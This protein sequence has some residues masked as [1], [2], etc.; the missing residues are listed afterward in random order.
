VP[1]TENPAPAGGAATWTSR[2]AYLLALVCL[3][4]GILIGYLFHG[5][6]APVA[7]VGQTL[8]TPAAPAA[9]P[10]APAESLQPLAAPLLMAIKADPKNV[11]ALVDLG[12]LYYDH[13]IYPQ[14][15]EYYTKALELNPNDVNVRTDL[16]TSYWYSGFADKAV[17][18]YEKSL[19]VDPTH[20]QTMFNLGIVRMDGL[21]DPAGAIA[22]WQKLLATNP[23]YPEKD[24]VLALIAQAKQQKP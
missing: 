6:S 10:G 13:R 15:I 9:Q 20:A 5:S 21:K 2:E 8:A 16:G 3:M 12:N 18:E 7:P 24:R 23:G 11:K 17:A 1:Q 22:V 19:K 4:V 14:A